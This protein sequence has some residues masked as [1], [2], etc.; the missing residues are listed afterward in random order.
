M[1]LDFDA[2]NIFAFAKDLKW[3]SIFTLA[4]V[5]LSSDYPTPRH[6]LRTEFSSA[7]KLM[8]REV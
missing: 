8:R 4:E 6:I 5:R 3:P 7:H 2:I 1:T